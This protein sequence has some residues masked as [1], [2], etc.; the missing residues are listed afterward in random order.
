MLVI[1]F[2]FEFVQESNPYLIRD[3]ADHISLS[4]LQMT[5]GLSEMKLNIVSLALHANSDK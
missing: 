3:L 5:K 2:S 1:G 4:A